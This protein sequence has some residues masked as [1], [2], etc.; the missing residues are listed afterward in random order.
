MTLICISIIISNFKPC[1]ICLLDSYTSLEKC[2]IKSLTH[3]WIEFLLLILEVFSIV[4]ILILYQIY[5][6]QLNDISHLPGVVLIVMKSSLSTSALFL[7][8]SVSY[9]KKSLTNL[10]SW[11]FSPVFSSKSFIFYFKG[12]NTKGS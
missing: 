1:F 6:S 5:Y 12:L 4:R 3:I 2:L 9:S 8:A 11:R 7:M 10:I